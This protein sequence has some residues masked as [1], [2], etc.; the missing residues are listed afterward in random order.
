[1]TDIEKFRSDIRRMQKYERAANGGRYNAAKVCAD[2]AA[3]FEREL[4]GLG[5]LPHSV[6]EYWIHTYIE[7]SADA[8]NEPSDANID[9]LGAMLSFL[10]GNTED[11][12]LLSKSDWKELGRLTGFE[13]EDLPIDI[14]SS[15]MTILVDHGA[16]A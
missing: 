11:G 9:K 14:L 5:E 13:A 10:D 2:A 16:L 3:A 1:M 8:A 15:L 4:N 12:E 7:N 6:T